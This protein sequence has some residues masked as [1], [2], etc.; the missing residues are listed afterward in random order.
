MSAIWQHELTTLKRLVARAERERQETEAQVAASR[1][2]KEKRAAR[3]NPAAI[4]AKAT[5]R[6]TILACLRRQTDPVSAYRVAEITNLKP[7]TCVRHLREMADEGIAE[8]VQKGTTRV[9]YA[10]NAEGKPTPD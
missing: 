7:D 5:C 4:R 6:E 2:S 10:I 3:P 9:R 1:L 8:A